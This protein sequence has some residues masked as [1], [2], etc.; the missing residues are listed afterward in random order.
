MIFGNL[1]E[2]IGLGFQEMILLI[3]LEYKK[4][5][6]DISNIP[7]SRYGSISWIDSNNN[8][9]LFGG[10]GIDSNNEHGKFNLIIENYLQHLDEK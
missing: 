8:L 1:M 4:G 3:N 10:F 5:I 6:P 2:N 7:G 9:W